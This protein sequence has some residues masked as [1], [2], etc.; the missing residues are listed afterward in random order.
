MKILAILILTTSCRL[1]DRTDFMVSL[2]DGRWV[3]DSTILSDSKVLKDCRNIDTKQSA[4]FIS[5]H[6]QAIIEIE[7]GN[8]D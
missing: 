7:E 5:A 2:P 1:I 4:S 3:C 6:Y 8:Y